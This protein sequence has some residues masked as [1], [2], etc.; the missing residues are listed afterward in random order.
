MLRSGS[1]RNDP[2]VRASIDVQAVR[3]KLEIPP[4]R[5]VVLYAPTFRDRDLRLNKPFEL[6]VDLDA[7]LAELGGDHY[8]LLRPHYLD[9]L[10]LL[11][12][13]QRLN[14]QHAA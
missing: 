8:F 9:K 4:G 14:P 6:Q 2:L 13:H 7:L 3:D 5:K 11:R 1:P 12:R 10:S